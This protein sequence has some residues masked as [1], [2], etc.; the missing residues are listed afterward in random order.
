MLDLK[1]EFMYNH[2]VIVTIYNVMIT[3]L[4]CMYIIEVIERCILVLDC[5]VTIYTYALNGMCIRLLM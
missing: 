2:K 5:S 3:C 1:I 4:I